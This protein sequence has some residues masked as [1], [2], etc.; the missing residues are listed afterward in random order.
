MDEKTTRYASARR[1][2]LGRVATIAAAIAAPLIVWLIAVPVAG[3]DLT[4]GSGAAAMTITPLS[5]VVVVLIAGLGAWGVI[6]LLERFVK[7][8]GRVFAIIG[9]TVLAL[10]LLLPITA[11]APG[12]VFVVLV[13]MHLVTGATLVIGLPLAARGRPA[14]SGDG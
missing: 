11:G 7:H 2:R 6:A 9:W 5:I 1:R 13:V 10:S 12:D 8:S 4:V 14:T 3:V